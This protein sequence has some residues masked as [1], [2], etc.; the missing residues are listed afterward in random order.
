MKQFKDAGLHEDI[1][2]AIGEMGFE[3][4]TPIQ[5]QVIPQILQSKSDLIGLAQT[6]TG[7]T[8]AFGLPVIHQTDA[9]SAQT[10]TLIL[11]PTREL[12]L[13][14]ARELKGYTK[15]SGG[16]G[17]VAVYGG[18]SAETQIKELRSNAQV[19]VGTPGR[20][21]DLLKRRKLNVSNIQRLILDEA[22]EMLSMGFQDELNAILERT[23]QEKQVMLFSATMP[24]AIAGMA[25]K[26][27]NQPVEISVGKKNTGADN[28][29]H[30]Y[31]LIRAKDRYPALRRIVDMNPGLYGIVFCRTR[32]ET[33]EIAE[34]LMQDGYDADALHGDLSQAQR[35]MIMKKFRMKHLRL[36][37]ATDVA[38]RGID[39]NDLTHIINYNLPD[40]PEV[41]IH[42]TGR[43]GRIGK[44]GEAVSLIHHKEKGKMRTIEK[45]AGKHIQQKDVPNGRDI[46]EKQ[47]LYYVDKLE[48]RE[49]DEKKTERLMPDVI[50][51]LEGLSREELIR[52]VVSLEFERFFSYYDD[53]PDLNV[54]RRDEKKDKMADRGKNQKNKKNKGI[55]AATGKAG[56]IKNSPHDDKVNGGSDLN[57]NTSSRKTDKD[58][59]AGKGSRRKRQ[60]R[61]N[62]GRVRLQNFYINKGKNQKLDKRELLR[63]INEQMND[64][65]LEIGKIDIQ[66]NLSFFEIDARYEN[67]LIRSFQN[68]TYNGSS[69]DVNL[70]KS[71]TGAGA[72]SH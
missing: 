25:N 57:G 64:R 45:M 49:V 72:L 41:Y 43:T 2:R 4:P 40:D 52:K 51:K 54:S 56:K 28:V 5:Q 71:S 44:K 14:I 61:K 55:D 32:R 15:Y 26:Y 48:N 16:I 58:T 8:A 10:Q 20:V 1:I 65:G 47:L 6:G 24:G 35:E 23:G 38:A 37:V 18:A 29:R 60:A 34:K 17:V 22:D 70:A 39:V 68:V 50:S 12:S 31:H 30:T 42:R 53:A 69:V 27:M 66:N 21:L 62:S 33:R 67:E 11:S 13:Q 9:T 59:S 46:C 19:V 3:E 36:L 63:L 7:K